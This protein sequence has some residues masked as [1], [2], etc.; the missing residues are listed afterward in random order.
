MS[1]DPKLLLD[2]L[3][4]AR[5]ARSFN[6]GVSAQQYAANVMLQYAT[7]RALQILGEAAWKVSD[8]FKA[9]HPEIPWDKIAGLRHRLVH[10]YGAVDQ[11]KLW[12]IVIE[13]LPPLIGQLEKLA[14]SEK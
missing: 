5:D 3:M 12:Q 1:R 7:E 14:P 6:T 13:Y 2:M 9:E 8:A 10:D 4:A 11:I